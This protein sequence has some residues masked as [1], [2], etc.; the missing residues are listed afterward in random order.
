MCDKP[1]KGLLI[2]CTSTTLISF[3]LGD[4]S[5]NALYFYRFPLYP[6]VVTKQALQHVADQQGYINRFFYINCYGNIHIKK[7]HHRSSSIFQIN[8]FSFG[9]YHKI[10]VFI[11]RFVIHGRPT[12]SY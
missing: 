8:G 9:L 11:I 5:V 10:S 3:T 2:G 1:L 6:I 7:I 4:Y 12:K